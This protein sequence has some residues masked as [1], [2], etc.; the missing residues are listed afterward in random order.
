MGRLQC[1]QV[2]TALSMCEPVVKAST[3]MAAAE[4]KE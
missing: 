2:S 1:K 4:E 3:E